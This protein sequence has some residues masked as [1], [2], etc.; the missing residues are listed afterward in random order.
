M[1]SKFGLTLGLAA[2]LMVGV[3]ATMLALGLFTTSEVEAQVTEA[4]AS[5]DPIVKGEATTITVKFVATTALTG[6]GDSAGTITINLDTDMTGPAP[7]DADEDA[8]AATLAG[9][10]I[11]GTTVSKSD[12]EYAID[13]GALVLEV[14]DMDGADGDDNHIPAGTMVTV[15]IPASAGITNPEMA[16][17]LTITVFTSEDTDPQT[18]AG[19]KVDP[20]VTNVSVSHSPDGTGAAARVTVEFTVESDLIPNV[21]IITIEF[22]DDVQVPPTLSNSDITVVKVTT[23]P[24]DL[25]DVTTA[26]ANPA[27]VTVSKTGVPADEPVVEVIVGNFERDPAMD[28]VGIAGMDRVSVVFQ[29][30]AGITNPN[31]AGTWN[32]KVKTNKDSTTKMVA[33]KDEDSFKT[34]RTLTL[35]GSSGSRGKSV[36]ATG[37]GYQKGTTGTVWL[38]KNTDGEIDTGEPVLC[39]EDIASNGTFDCGFKANVP[40]FEAGITNMVNAID[41]RDGAASALS[42]WK[43][44]P[45]I[46]AVPDSAAVGETINVELLDFDSAQA[47]AKFEI[48]GIPITHVVGTATENLIPDPGMKSITITI[49]NGVALGQQA[50]RLQNS[51]K[52]DGTSGSSYRD[53]MTIGGA[54][55]SLSPSTVVPNQ[56]VTVTGRGFT[57]DL[58]L[59]TF[60]IGGIKVTTPVNAG[61]SGSSSDLEV[62]SGGNWI[63]TVIIPVEPPSTVPGTYEFKAQD[64]GDRPGVTQVTLAP[65]TITFDP[66]ES[67]TGTTVTVTGSGWPASNSNSNYNASVKVEYILSGQGDNASVSTSVTP[68]SNGNFTA[69]IRV[70]LNAQIPSTNKVKVSFDGTGTTGQIMQ[71]VAHRVPGARITVT[72][73]SGSGGTIA[74]LTGDGFKGFT[75]L[76]DVTVGGIV[77]VPSPGSPS[78]GRDGVLA[79]SQILIPGLDPGTHTVRVTVSGTVV[80]TPFTITADDAAPTTGAGDVPV[81]D[82]LQAL[83]DNM[84]NGSPN[85]VDAYLFDDST[86]TYLSYLTDPDFASLNDLETVKSGDILWIR[87]Q[88][89]QMFAGKTLAVPWTQ[90]VLP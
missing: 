36:T 37:G 78:V 71:Q 23:D 15:I 62:D 53:T 77:V 1:K 46:V 6:G 18:A 52:A 5:N 56:S 84:V 79:S 42:E 14:P 69:Q 70:P 38:D 64:D 19:A 89:S 39:S 60:Y 72:P 82:A 2:T 4:S 48:G 57:K 59:K 61:L 47:F 86:Q 83:I 80:S 20:E 90:V 66:P 54:M 33:S 49:P 28:A 87:V 44:T 40:P 9:V 68:D 65:R 55:V 43:V 27:G 12:A 50:L 76:T 35:S 29:Q 13:T 41:G 30:T 31:A 63:G 74:T 32:V 8:N 73:S 21:D 58:E 10:T 17:A 11:N 88:E 16:Q 45:Q 51:K 3:F 7:D 67:R 81:A 26:T 75:T 85:L 34:A 22:E 25:T 24:N